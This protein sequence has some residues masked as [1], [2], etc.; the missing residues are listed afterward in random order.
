M[1]LIFRTAVI[2][3]AALTLS[4]CASGIPF[5]QMQ[6]RETAVDPEMGRVFL[7]RATSI[8]AAVQPRITM[9]DEVIGVS[10]AQGFFYV[11]RPSGEYVIQ[12]TTEVERRVSFVLDP[13]QTRYVKFKVGMGF[14]VGHVYGELVD[15]E[16]G[17]A[18]IQKC[19]YTGELL[20]SD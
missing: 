17:R 18:E 13:G 7:Y 8:G 5:T 14:F 16:V 11:D 12:T 10:K 19:K 1:K 3:A 20:E 15:N 4:A 9:N 2:L 6:P